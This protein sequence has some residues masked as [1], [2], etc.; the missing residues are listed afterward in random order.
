MTADP[1]CPLCK[2]PIPAG[3]RQSEH[4][5]IPKLKGGAKGPRILVH[6]ICHSEIHATL[7]EAEIAR[8]YA[9]VDALKQ[10]P[11]LEKF[12]AWVADKPPDFYKRSVGGR[13]KKR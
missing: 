8:S 7:T 1:I 12:F 10:H 11:R 5:L 3:V 6:Q 2:R 13:R 9:T 4:H